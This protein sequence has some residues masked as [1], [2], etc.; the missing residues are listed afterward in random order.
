MR[1][2]SNCKVRNNAK[3]LGP[4]IGCPIP[5]KMIN[6]ATHGPRAV[7]PLVLALYHERGKIN[8]NNTEQTMKLTGPL[9]KHFN[10]PDGHRK[11]DAL[12]WASDQ[13]LITIIKNGKGIVPQIKLN[14]GPYWE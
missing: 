11:Q 9:C 6:T 5:V 3:I 8:R 12:K 4:Y 14:D 13:G 1:N 7:L 10:I 2:L